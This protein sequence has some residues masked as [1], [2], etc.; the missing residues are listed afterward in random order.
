MP[1]GPGPQPFRA[2]ALALAATFALAAMP[3]ALADDIPTEL[4]IPLQPWRDNVDPDGCKPVPVDPQ[5]NGACINQDLAV[6]NVD[7][8][9]TDCLRLDDEGLPC[10]KDLC[11]DDQCAHPEGCLSDGNTCFHLGAAADA[12]AQPGPDPCAS[13]TLH[14]LLSTPLPSAHACAGDEG[15]ACVSW[16]SFVAE[17]VTRA[18]EGTGVCESAVGA[19][20]I[21][22]ADGTGACVAGAC[23][24]LRCGQPHSI[25]DLCVEEDPA[26][27][28]TPDLPNR[29][30]FDGSK[31]C[32][33]NTP[34][35][36]GD[37]SDCTGSCHGVVRDGETLCT[38]TVSDVRA[39]CVGP[40]EGGIEVCH[41]P[42]CVTLPVDCALDPIA[43]LDPVPG[44]LGACYTSI[45]VTAASRECV[46]VALGACQQGWPTGTRP[47]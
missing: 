42:T 18:Q 4:C 27:V 24:D 12:C 16:P 21:A 13:L 19:C 17:C 44:G 33:T 28:R 11:L 6:G 35:C 37:V 29:A 8:E 1:T 9:P 23:I 41:V 2:L 7:R 45:C 39:T 10:Y 5:P 26:C 14:P 3:A 32:V 31:L 15:E 36:A 30:C 25:Q 20:L 40:T 43:C 46:L 22:E 38:E 47:F 34:A